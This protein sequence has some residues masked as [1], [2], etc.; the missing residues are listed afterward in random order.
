LEKQ[1]SPQQVAAA[2]RRTKELRTQI[3]AKLKSGGK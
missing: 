3:E 1:M 2:Q